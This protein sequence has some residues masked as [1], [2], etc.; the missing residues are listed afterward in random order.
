MAA[1][2]AGRILALRG[3][4][5]HDQGA[6]TARGANIPYNSATTILGPYVVPNYR[7]AVRVAHTNKVCVTSIRGA[8]H[9]QGCFTMERLLD[10]VAAACGLDRTEVRRRNMIAADAMPY[11]HP[12]RTQAGQNII[13]DSG[14]YPA[15]QQ[16][17]EEAVDYDGFPARRDAARAEGRYLGIAVANYVKPTGRGPFEMGLV[18]VGTS[19]KVS[20]YTG[21]VAMGQGFRTAMSQ[22]CAERLGVDMDDVIVVAGDTA[23]VPHGMGGF[24]SRQT[25]NAGSSIHLAAGEVRDKALKVA[26]HMLEAAEAD[27]EL[28]GGRVRVRGVPG[29]SVGLGEIA[30]A[31]AGTSSPTTW[32]TPTAPTAW[33]SRSTRTPAACA[34]CAMWWCT[35]A[36]G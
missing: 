28:V 30:H 34:S 1:D 21:A 7:M 35:T 6:Y 17:A 14:D 2:G 23:S 10:R 3:T 11:T 13:Y 27:L 8:G 15:C 22:L 9:P 31:V 20:V 36:A 24:A 29:M 19:G 16:A 5:Y 33:R 32:S 4:L 18:R 12:L 25:V 26:A